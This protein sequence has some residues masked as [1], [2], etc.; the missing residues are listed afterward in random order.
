[1]IALLMGCDDPT[2]WAPPTSLARTG[3]DAGS[4]SLSWTN[5]GSHPVEIYFDGVL[6]ATKS[7]GSTSHTESSLSPNTVYAVR[8]RYRS[9]GNYSPLTAPV[10]MATTL[11]TP[12][13]P[14]AEVV[15]R[16][17][18]LTWTNTTPNAPIEVWRETDGGGFTLQTTLAAG[19]AAY[20]QAGLAD[21][22]YTYK[23]RYN[24]VGTT[25]SY[26]GTEDAVVLASVNP[27]TTPMSATTVSDT[28]IDLAWTLGTAGAATEIYRGTSTG[29]TTLL[30]TTAEGATTFSDT[31]LSPSTQYYYR[32]KGT[33]SGVTSTG[34]SDEVNATTGTPPAG[35]PTGLAADT[36][37][38]D[39]VALS[40]TNG[41]AGAT[42][43]IYRGT[44]PNPTTLLTTKS[45]TTTSHN[46]DTVVAGT[47]Y[48]YR[49]RHILNTYPS[50]YTSDVTAAVP[51]P[52]ISG[53]SITGIAEDTFVTMSWTL[54]AGP[55]GVTFSAGAW[56]DGD[57]A[58]GVQVDA[59]S[60]PYAA[61]LGFT[62][63][64]K[65]PGVNHEVTV[66]IPLLM[67]NAGGTTVLTSNAFSITLYK[68][69]AA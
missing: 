12:G 5:T 45:A 16:F 52:A 35:P 51:V 41:D 48:Y 9:G 15:L 60:S 11:P 7:A 38:T 42:I 22:T 63:K 33:K 32:F 50:V 3:G 44:S 59:I 58:S 57:G 26:S 46:D 20:S 19:T 31:G 30:T 56:S 55:V 14:V 67:K 49:I 18:S 66:S 8:I 4:V 10:P 2:V 37:Y 69:N 13:T 25:G 23:L 65:V 17:V 6:A 29:P 54:V 61:P 1:M 36:T 27:P 53:A 62:I 64:T 39:R 43:E 24:V 40:W 21:A 47:T 34:Y 68:G 28:A